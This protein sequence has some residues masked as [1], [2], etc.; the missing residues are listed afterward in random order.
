MIVR[1]ELHQ[2]ARVGPVRA[3]N[4]DNHRRLDRGKQRLNDCFPESVHDPTSCAWRVRR[5]QLFAA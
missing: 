5:A 1:A 2:I 3:A 4:F